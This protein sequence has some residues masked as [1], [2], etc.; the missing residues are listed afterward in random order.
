MRR[1]CISLLECRSP[2]RRVPRGL[3]TAAPK[4]VEPDRD[5]GA[6]RVE[7]TPWVSEESGVRVCFSAAGWFRH[8]RSLALTSWL[9]QHLVNKPLGKY[10]QEL[11]VWLAVFLLEKLGR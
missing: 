11:K 9:N 5:E 6:V 8:S 7:T 3:C 1:L 10:P 4:L 2:P